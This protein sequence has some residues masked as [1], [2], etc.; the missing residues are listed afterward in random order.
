MSTSTNGHSGRRLVATVI[1][2]VLVASALVVFRQPLIAQLTGKDPGGASAQAGGGLPNAPS[3]ARRR[4][5]HLFDAPLGERAGARQ[6]PHL[7]HDPRAGD[8]AAAGAGHRDD[9]RGAPPAHRSSHRTRR[10]GA[11]AR[12][13]PCRRPRHLRR[14]HPLG[15]EPQGARVDHQAVRERTGSARDPWRDAPHDVQ[16]GAL[17]RRAG[18]PP[19]RAAQID[20]RSRRLRGAESRGALRTGIAP[21]AAPARPQ[22]RAD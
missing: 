12:E 19:R 5:L 11:D 16:P 18:L 9:R 21:A 2:G 13:H 1:V 3:A 17:Q 7:R 10:P 22:R 6:V 20:R 14:V 8:Q 4:S 15:R